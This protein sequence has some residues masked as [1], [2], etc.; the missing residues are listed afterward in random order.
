MIT[1]TDPFIFKVLDVSTGH[2]T[3]EDNLGLAANSVDSAKALV[4]VY[5][6]GE[7]GWLVYIGELDDNWPAEDWSEAFRTVLKKALELGCE[8]VRWDRDGKKYD[9]LETFDW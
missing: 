1:L 4:P 7:Y 9:E 6:L 8:Y 5:E 2:M 3:H